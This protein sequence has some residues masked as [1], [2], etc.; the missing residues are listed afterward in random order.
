[1]PDEA[2]LYYEKAIQYRPDFVDAHWNMACALLL[3]G[4]V[5]RGWKEYE[6]RWK[7]K[8]HRGS[9]IS[10]PRWNGSDISGLTILLHAEQAFG[11]TIQFIRYAPLV[12]QKCARVIV[13]SP[14]ELVRLLGNVQGIEQVVPYGD[15]LPEFNMHCPLLSLPLIF[16]TSLSS[17]PA[18]IPYINVDASLSQKW[19]DRLQHDRSRMKIGLVWTGRIKTE[20]NAGVPVPLI[21]SHI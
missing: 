5:E 16:G 19:K 7:L 11:D 10:G 9:N 17:I 15:Q 18:Q 6:W 8:G 14:K 3:S 21:C 2:I 4:E 12:A 13:Q 1:M 20:E